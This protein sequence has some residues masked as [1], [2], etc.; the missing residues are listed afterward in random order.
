MSTVI[1]TN[2]TIRQYCNTCKESAGFYCNGCNRVFC[3]NHADQHR[4]TLYEQFDWLTVDHDDLLQKLNNTLAIM[5]KTHPSRKIIDKWEEESIKQIQQTANEARCALTDALKIHMNDMKEKLKSLSEQLNQISENQNST[6]DERNIKQWAT[7]L[8]DIKHEFITTPTFTVRIHGNKPV[9]MP[10]IKIQPDRI[11]ENSSNH[12]HQQRQQHNPSG[13]VSIKPSS[14]NPFEILY[15]NTKQEKAIDHNS[16]SIS[17][18]DDRFCYHSNHVKIIDNGQIFIHD[19]TKNDAS[20]RG[21]NE[22]SHGEQTLFFRIEHMTS[23][24]WIFFGIISKHASF[25]QKAYLNSSVH[26][27]TGY[28]NVYINGKSM[29][30]LNGYLN[31]MKVHDFV[32]L[33]IDCDK[34]T[35]YLWHS[36]QS[37]KNKLPVDIRTCP[38]PWQFLISCH[39]TNDSVRILPLAIG[40][41]IQREQEKLNNNMKIKEIQLKNQNDSPSP[42]PQKFMTTDSV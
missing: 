34:Q 19:S 26:G 41:I 24:D 21:F 29:P 39:N 2:E 27:W 22:Y 18:K 11:H 40:S 17:Q 4:Q 16:N 42:I 3:Q 12:H 28:N 8:R 13:L 32:E 5:Q 37:Y 23:N 31:E 7:E 20:I 33:T 15:H 1:V 6:F 35:L 25:D 14:S 36:R 10:I 9:V 30:V 38:F